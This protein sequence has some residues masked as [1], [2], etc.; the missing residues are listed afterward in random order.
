MWAP[1]RT[2]PD[3]KSK[4]VPSSNS[5]P[6]IRIDQN[7]IETRYASMEE[8]STKNGYDRSYIGSILRGRI[9]NRTPYKWRYENSDVIK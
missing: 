7:G 5:R 1:F 8:A 4:G 9:K 2:T 6:V 3:H